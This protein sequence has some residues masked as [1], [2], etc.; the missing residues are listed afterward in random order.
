[1]TKKSVYKNI[2]MIPVV[3]TSTITNV[4]NNKA[5]INVVFLNNSR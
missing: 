1:M 4:Q 2:C 3:P 5:E